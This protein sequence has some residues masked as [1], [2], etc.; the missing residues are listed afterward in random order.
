MPTNYTQ[1]QLSD[2]VSVDIFLNGDG[3][4]PDFAIAEQGF[5]PNIAEWLRA[6]LG[7]RPAYSDVTE[8]IRV[9]LFGTAN[10]LPTINNLMSL[11]TQAR[12]WAA[13][14]NVS[15]VT[16]RVFPQGSTTEWRAVVT[17]GSVDM[18]SDWTDKLLL[19]SI[20]GITI[21][22]TRR[23]QW[24][25]ADGTG[26]ASTS[27]S[28]VRP[29]QLNSTSIAQTGEGL[30]TK[31]RIASMNV[32]SA[33]VKSGTLIVAGSDKIKMVFATAATGGSTISD[34]TSM[35]GSIKRVAAGS[36]NYIAFTIPAISARRVHLFAS[37]RSGSG[38]SIDLNFYPG[39]DYGKVTFYPYYGSSDGRVTY[40]GEFDLPDQ[41]GVINFSNASAQFD[42]DY[43]CLVAADD[44]SIAII[45]TESLLQQTQLGL[46]MN[47][48]DPIDVRIE[49]NP[50]SDFAP[51]VTIVHKDP[52]YLDYDIAVKVPVLGDTWL[53]HTGG[54]VYYVQ[55]AQGYSA[56]CPLNGAA[57][58]PAS[59]TLYIDKM[60]ACLIP[61]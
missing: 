43:I 42:I 20:D 9:N 10:P 48:S 39:R 57:T 8:T 60:R 1:I 61:T 53:K 7:A 52:I 22:L 13:G 2:G 21:T 27:I 31:L 49:N 41:Y 55:L 15:P 25:V 33:Y 11:F 35:A 51:V 26:T 37:I 28:N 40:V 5:S 14:E 29:N 46:L 45:D 3:S 18:P 19:K 23:G 34:S 36:G 17:D 44:S 16:I 38:T 30:L 59:Y 47:T 6:A 12:R 56:W 50:V 24:F 58:A 54:T 32:N 4:D